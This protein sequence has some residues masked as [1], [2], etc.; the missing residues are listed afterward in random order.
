MAEETE[1]LQNQ[2]KLWRELEQH[3]AWILFKR[4]A[5]EQ[6]KGVMN[7]GVSTKDPYVMAK[8]W[9]A[10]GMYQALMVLPELSVKALQMRLTNRKEDTDGN[11]E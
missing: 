10:Y 4:A 2:L 5:Y 7:E 8:D 6:C 3:P 1:E 9:G 11:R